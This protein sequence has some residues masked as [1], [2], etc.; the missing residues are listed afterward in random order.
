MGKLT[1][2]LIVGLWFY[3]AASASTALVIEAEEAAVRTEGGPNPGGGMLRSDLSPKPVHEQLRQ[4]IHK[5]W[6]TRTSGATDADGRFAFRGFCGD[7]RITLER[8]EGNM[9]QKMSLK[10]NERQELSI[11]L[12][13]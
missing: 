13:K 2:A 4:L 11:T 10:K 1:A 3:P 7:Y 6:K 8:P 12:P 9:E 5:E